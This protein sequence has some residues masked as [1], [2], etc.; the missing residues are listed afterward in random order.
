[1]SQRHRFMWFAV[2]LIALIAGEVVQYLGY[3]A[4]APLPLL[5]AS[6]LLIVLHRSHRILSALGSSLVFL[7][8]AESTLSPGSMVTTA[9]LWV[10]LV[11]ALALALEWRRFHI[12]RHAWAVVLFGAALV[13][14]T[15][16]GGDLTLTAKTIGIA[17]L[18]VFA[19]TAAANL[20]RAHRSPLF[21]FVIVAGCV[22]AVLAIC[23]SLLRSE[24]VR[25]YITGNASD[26]YL[27]RVNLI[28]GDW[29]NRAQGTM[30]YAIPFGAFI[31]TAILVCVF[32]PVV[33]N[34]YVR[35]AVVALL[36][37]AILLSGARSSIAALALGLGVGFVV[38]ALRARKNN[39]RVRGL[40]W[41]VLGVAVLG[42][43][44]LL[45]FIRA[46]STGDFSLLHRGGVLASGTNMFGLPPLQLWF[47][48]GYDSAR[49]LFES[50]VLFAATGQP[51]VDNTLL[52]ALIFSGI[53]GLASL[54][55]IVVLAFIRSDALGRSVLAAAFVLFFFYDLFSWHL[56]AFLLFTFV[57]FAAVRD[58]RDTESHDVTDTEVEQPLTQ[59]TEHTVAG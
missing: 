28:L 11:L 7:L 29:T 18:W 53:L 41:I 55:T 45:F 37:V 14:P 13:I 50:G 20:P 24:L 31:V 48:S 19:F 6:I 30:G 15:F 36:S 33:K 52:T 10:S 16:V 44:G 26:G 59:N 3:Y 25:T 47:G 1:M 32:S 21:G 4:L 40:T 34:G 51:I 9:P 17:G 58:R 57:G 23:E 54:I 42:G 35:A 43:A 22:E 49:E 12:P 5:V 27:V 56:S 46:L 8:I 39:R 38:I 2:G